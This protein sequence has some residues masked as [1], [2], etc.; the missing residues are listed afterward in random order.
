LLDEYLGILATWAF[1][2]HKHAHKAFKK[3]NPILEA[4]IKG[5][6]ASDAGALK[7]CMVAIATGREPATMADRYRV[8]YNTAAR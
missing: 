6:K 4:V 8:S 7:D 2:Q 3:S 1:D 5:S